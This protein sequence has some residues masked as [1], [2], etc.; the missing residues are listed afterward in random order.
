MAPA[1]AEYPS[2]AFQLVALNLAGSPWHAA[3]LHVRSDE[4]DI[5]PQALLPEAKL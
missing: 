2:G 4:S 5:T 1:A 3:D